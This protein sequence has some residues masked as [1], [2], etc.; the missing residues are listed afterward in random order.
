MESANSQIVVALLRGGNAATEL[1]IDAGMNIGWYSLLGASVGYRVLSFELQSRCL[2]ISAAILHANN[3][4]ARVTVLRTALGASV[5]SM[6][7]PMSATSC[8]GGYQARSH[9]PVQARVQADASTGADTLPLTTVPTALQSWV[10]QCGSSAQLPVVRLLKADVEGSEVGM[11][12]GSEPMLLSRPGAVRNILME[13]SPHQQFSSSLNATAAYMTT[14]CDEH[15]F[16]AFQLWS[17]AASRTFAGL[18]PEWR[19]AFAEYARCNLIEF[20]QDPPLQRIVDWHAYTNDFRR[21]RGMQTNV[22][23]VW[24]SR[25]SRRR[26]RHPA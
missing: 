23:L 11:L 22:W 15:D 9:S 6:Q 2:G 1:F 10:D 21:H 14:F 7:L 3:M 13:Y 16:D 20:A 18:V 26:N 24:R 25:R 17:W 8:S 5:G 19:P 12:R 4:R